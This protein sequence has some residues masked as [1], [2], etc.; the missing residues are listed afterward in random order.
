MLPTVTVPIRSL[1]SPVTVDATNAQV[2]ATTTRGETP[3]VEAS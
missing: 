1:P 2:R 3:R